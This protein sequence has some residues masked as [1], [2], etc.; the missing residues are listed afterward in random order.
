MKGPALVLRVPV[1]DIKGTCAACRLV[2]P[3][4]ALEAVPTRPDLDRCRDGE[5]CA[6]RFRPRRLARSVWGRRP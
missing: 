4:G 3:F 6:D 2:L 5:A 1:P